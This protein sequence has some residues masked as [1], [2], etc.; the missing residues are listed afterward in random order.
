MD[1]VLATLPSTAVEAAIAQCTSHCTVARGHRLNTSIVLAAVHSLSGLLGAI[2]AVTLLPSSPPV[3]VPSKQ[4][5]LR[6]RKEKWSCSH[7]WNW[8]KIIVHSLDN[9]VQHGSQT[10]LVEI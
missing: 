3:P 6:G 8:S 7:V 9:A 2:S 1:I 5:R 4:P 10:E